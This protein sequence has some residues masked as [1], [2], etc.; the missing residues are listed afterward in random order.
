MFNHTDRAVLYAIA[1]KLDLSIEL[2]L[3]TLNKETSMSKELDDLTA[4]VKRSKTVSD[5]IVTLVQGL[6]QQLRDAA[7][8]P[9]AIEALA[10]E[11]DA[12]TG[13]VSDAVTANTPAGQAAPAA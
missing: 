12:K 2:D 11:L 3:A 5:S 9:A 10:A 8:D 7:S 13:A 4:S 1:R 6:A